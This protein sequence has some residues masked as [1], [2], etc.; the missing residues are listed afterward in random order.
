MKRLWKLRSFR[1]AAYSLAAIVVI[2]VS[3]CSYEI[4]A[5]DA[6]ERI[7][8]VTEP[9]WSDRI[10][11]IGSI[12]FRSWGGKWI[13]TDCDTEI[14]FLAGHEVIMTEYGNGVSQSKGIYSTDPSGQIEIKLEKLRHDW[15]SMI[16]ERDGIS[17]RLRPEKRGMGF[18]IGNR[19]GATMRDRQGSYWPFRPVTVDEEQ[20]IRKKWRI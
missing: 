17:L 6:A 8:P 13:G 11:L 5:G 1:F 9:D 14:T 2:I 16:L 12:T 7:N 3:Y 4:L 20:M 15:P 19:G 18:I 10:K